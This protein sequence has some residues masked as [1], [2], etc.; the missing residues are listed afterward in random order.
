MDNHTF[1]IMRR[2]YGDLVVAF[3]PGSV[4]YDNCFICGRD[5][6]WNGTLLAPR[7]QW[8]EETGECLSD[9]L[10]GA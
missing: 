1:N 6:N 7:G 8:G 4:T 10:N 2:Q 9:I 5:Y 3:A